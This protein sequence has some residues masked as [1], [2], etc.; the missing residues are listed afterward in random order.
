LEPQAFPAWV[1]ARRRDRSLR[2]DDA[3]VLRIDVV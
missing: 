2:N 1:A 3:T